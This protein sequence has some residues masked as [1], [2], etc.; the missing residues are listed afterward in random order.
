M[1]TRNIL[2]TSEVLRAQMSGL[3]KMKIK[4]SQAKSFMK[5]N[6]KNKFKFPVEKYKYIFHFFKT[7]ALNLE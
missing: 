5:S 4:T 7:F 1:S 2:H 6:C 3:I